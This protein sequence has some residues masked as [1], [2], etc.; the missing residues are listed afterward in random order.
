MEGFQR[1]ALTLHGLGH[2][3]ANKASDFHELV[4]GKI[5]KV[6]VDGFG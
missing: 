6:L 5:L 3:I 4:V 1:L 2:E